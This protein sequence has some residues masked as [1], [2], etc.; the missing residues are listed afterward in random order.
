MRGLLAAIDPTADL[1]PSR[2]AARHILI[3][4]YIGDLGERLWPVRITRTAVAE[5]RRAHGGGVVGQSPYNQFTHAKAFTPVDLKVA[6]RPMCYFQVAAGDIGAA[7]DS[8]RPF[9]L[10]VP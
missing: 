5:L 8:Q 3:G 9:L 1:D 7:N 6:V 10:A 4:Q 2:Q